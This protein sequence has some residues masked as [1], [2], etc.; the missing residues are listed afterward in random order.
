MS[1][2]QAGDLVKTGPTHYLVTINKMI[3]EIVDLEPA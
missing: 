3:V 2:L 1:A